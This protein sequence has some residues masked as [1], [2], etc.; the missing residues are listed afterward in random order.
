MAGNKDILVV[1]SRR[2]SGDPL[3]KMGSM[4]AAKENWRESCLHARSR[5]QACFSTPPLPMCS[6]VFFFFF[7]NAF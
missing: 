4:I 7:H 2:Q 3:G 1:G 6:R 5:C